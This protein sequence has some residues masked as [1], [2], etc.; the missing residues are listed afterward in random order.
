M[1]VRRREGQ[2]RGPETHLAREAGTNRLLLH[3]RL[4]W[5]GGRRGRSG[6]RW[7][8]EHRSRED[9][10]QPYS[11]RRSAI[12]FPAQHE[13]LHELPVTT[14]GVASQQKH[15]SNPLGKRTWDGGGPR[16]EPAAD[17]FDGAERGEVDHGVGA[18]EARV[19][20]QFA[21]GRLY[22]SPLRNQPST[23]ES[24]LL[25]RPPRSFVHAAL[26]KVGLGPT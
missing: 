9:G 19:R 8:V 25:C 24:E 13:K 10:I 23:T 6:R 1:S 21:L 3:L 11:T 15:K 16:R 5:F 20:G 17:A 2:E 22:S 18:V 12:V 26:E 14:A 4:R 7:R